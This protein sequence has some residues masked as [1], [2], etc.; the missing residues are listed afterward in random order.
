MTNL[1]VKLDNI[2]SLCELNQLINS[3]KQVRIGHS[4]MGTKIFEVEGFEGSLSL[5]VLWR[6]YNHHIKNP[7][8]LSLKDR[9]HAINVANTLRKIEKQTPSIKT[10]TGLFGMIYKVG[11]FLRQLFVSDGHIYN[12]F[13]PPKNNDRMLEFTSEEYMNTVFDLAFKLSPDTNSHS[14]PL[15]KVENQKYYV[16]EETL[17]RLAEIA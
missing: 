15:I 14:H 5:L 12:S 9:V 4:F 16:N 3:G 17:R 13:D 1:R 8:L 10:P 6:N 2:T 7:A 11:V